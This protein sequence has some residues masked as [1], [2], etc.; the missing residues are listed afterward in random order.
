MNRYFAP[1]FFMILAQVSL[2]AGAASQIELVDGTAIQGDVVSAAH[3]RYVIHSATLGQIELPESS[4]RSIRPGVESGPGSTSGANLLS[5]QKQI[6]SSPE[7]LQ[8]VTALL[9]DPQ[10]QAAMND[11][12]LRQLVISGNLDALRSDPRILRLLAHPSIQEIVG[13]VNGQ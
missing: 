3:G 13:K 9:A 8:M 10:L 6:V 4:I 2:P 11:P 12:E 1:L 7:L 5:I